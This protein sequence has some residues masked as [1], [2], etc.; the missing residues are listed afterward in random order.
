M[1]GSKVRAVRERGGEAVLPAAF[2]R[3][4]FLGWLKL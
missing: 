4:Y 1:T 3:G 2:G